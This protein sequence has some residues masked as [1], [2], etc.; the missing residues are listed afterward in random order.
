MFLG[1]KVVWKHVFLHFRPKDY[2]P[3]ESGNPS[4]T[5]QT[6]VLKAKG[7]PCTRRSISQH[8]A[9]ERRRNSNR[10]HLEA[11]KCSNSTAVSLVT[12]CDTLPEPHCCMLWDIPGSMQVWRRGK[13]RSAQECSSFTDHAT[14]ACP[15]GQPRYAVKWPLELVLRQHTESNRSLQSSKPWGGKE[16][17]C[18]EQFYPRRNVVENCIAPG[19]TVFS[20]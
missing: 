12:M 8:T 6:G 18:C 15:L 7:R 3:A 4:V 5:N 10:M 2:M 9:L 16:G 11:C 14:F 1:A 17:Q 20:T 13:A 19:N